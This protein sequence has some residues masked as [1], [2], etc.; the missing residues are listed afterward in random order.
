VAWGSTYLAIRFA[1]ETMPPFF[2]AAFRFLFSALSS[3]LWR[4]VSETGRRLVQSGARQTI[5]GILLLVGGNGGVVWPSNG[6][7]RCCIACRYYGSA[8]DGLDGHASSGRT[9]GR[10]GLRYQAF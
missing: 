6:G 10:G 1:I 3:I 9:V 4:R 2:M 5:I 8:L 7:L